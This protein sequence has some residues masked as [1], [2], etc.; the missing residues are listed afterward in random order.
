MRPVRG[1]G[2]SVLQGPCARDWEPEPGVDMEIP[3]FWKMVTA[4]SGKCALL[5]VSLGQASSDRI[6]EPAPGRANGGAA[7]EV[8]AV[9][10]KDGPDPTYGIGGHGGAGESGMAERGGGQKSPVGS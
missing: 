9:R 5:P 10:E 8:H 2:V 4:V 3:A 1:L 7:A 6:V